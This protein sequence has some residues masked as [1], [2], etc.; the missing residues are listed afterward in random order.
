MQEELAAL[1][2]A[3]QFT[4][5]LASAPRPPDR[6]FWEERIGRCSSAGFLCAVHC[7]V[8]ALQQR[9]PILPIIWVQTH[10]DAG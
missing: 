6:S 7:G 8:G 5:Q 10:A 4:L 9:I 3:V 1:E 2:C